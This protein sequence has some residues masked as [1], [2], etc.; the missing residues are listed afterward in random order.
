[1]F[2]TTDSDQNFTAASTKKNSNSRRF[3]PI[4]RGQYKY[5]RMQHPTTS[6]HG[7]HLTLASIESHLKEHSKKLEELRRAIAYPSPTKWLSPKEFGQLVGK[8][9]D[10]I[11][12]LAKLGVFKAESIREKPTKSGVRRHYHAA[13]AVKDFESYKLNCGGSL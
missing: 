8:H 10:H 1:M 12:R 4:R 11:C 5:Q 3:H 2:Y 6:S 13:K 7:F 9:P